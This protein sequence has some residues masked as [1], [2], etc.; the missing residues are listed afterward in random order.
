MNPNSIIIYGLAGADKKYKA[1]AYYNIPEGDFSITNM[2]YQASV[3]KAKKP[4]IEYIYVID[5]RKGLK[6]DYIESY[7][8]NTIASCV[9]FKMMLE[10]YGHRIDIDL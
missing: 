1:L 2:L 7:K 4:E 8:T 10:K 9:E 5:N 3:L 6:R